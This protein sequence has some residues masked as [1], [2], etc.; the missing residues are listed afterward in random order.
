MPNA[1]LHVVGRNPP[2][3]LARRLS[4]RGVTVTGDVDDV[5]P[6]LARAALVVVPLRIG[7]GTRLK[8]LEAWAAGKA[9]LSTSLGA[10]GLPAVDGENIALEDDPDRM[11]DRAVALLSDQAATSSLGDN[12]RR[13]A[14]ERFG[15]NVVVEQLLAAYAESVNGRAR[16]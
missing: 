5:R 8:I 11:A 9:V 16:R 1:E 7:G 14:V 6:E 13:I 12:G 3:A 10:E 2:T 4:V 15:W